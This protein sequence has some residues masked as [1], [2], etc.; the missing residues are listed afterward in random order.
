MLMESDYPV[1]DPAPARL[2]G[3]A[4]GMPKNDLSMIMGGTAA[5]LLGID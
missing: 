2:L 1:G 4:E 5:R 3:L